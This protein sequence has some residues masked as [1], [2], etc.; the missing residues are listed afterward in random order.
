MCNLYLIGL[1]WENVKILLNKN[2]TADMNFQKLLQ[3]TND[4][5]SLVTQDKMCRHL[6]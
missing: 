2:I 4:T 6:L 5:V 3:V 1:T